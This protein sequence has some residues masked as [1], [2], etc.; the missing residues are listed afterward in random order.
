VPHRARIKR[1]AA[2][3]TGTGLVSGPIARTCWQASSLSFLAAEETGQG[4]GCSQ[5]DDAEGRHRHWR[6]A[7]GVLWPAKAPADDV[8][9]IAA[10]LRYKTDIQYLGD[11][12]RWSAARVLSGRCATPV[13]GRAGRRLAATGRGGTGWDWPGIGSWPLWRR[14]DVGYVEQAVDRA[15]CRVLAGAGV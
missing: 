9:D 2:Q 4:R 11:G 8:R 12:R 5:A 14:G 13:V 7:A 15:S 1:D 10:S 6:R 3:L